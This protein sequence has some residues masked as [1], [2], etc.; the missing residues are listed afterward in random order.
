MAGHCYAHRI[1]DCF[2]TATGHFE[3]FRFC[4]G[5][6]PA[7]L[8]LPFQQLTGS[9]LALRSLVSIGCR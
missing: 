2:E 9:A 5:Q 7:R 3:K 6:S 1:E 4:S 8:Q